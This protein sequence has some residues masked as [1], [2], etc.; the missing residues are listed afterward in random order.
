MEEELKLSVLEKRSFERGVASSRIRLKA[1]RIIWDELEKKLGA[2][3]GDEKKDA[4]H[5]FAFKKEVDARPYY[6]QFALIEWLEAQ[7]E[8]YPELLGGGRKELNRVMKIYQEHL[9]TLRPSKKK[10]AA[11][12]ESETESDG[13]ENISAIDGTRLFN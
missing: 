4:D 2:G 6:E 9:E 3:T 11:K 12:A 10:A 13:I 8:N 1:G 7:I 5:L